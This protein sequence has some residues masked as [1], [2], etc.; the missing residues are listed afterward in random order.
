MLK[1][2]WKGLR[3]IEIAIMA[4][5]ITMLIAVVCSHYDHFACRSMQSEAKFSL[6]EI[7]NAQL[8]YHAEYDRFATVKK[9]ITE[10]LRVVVAQKYYDFSDAVAPNQDS[11]TIL[12]TGKAQTLVAG[13]IWSIDEKKR[14]INL[15]P[16]CAQP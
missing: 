2:F 16:I 13:E 5:L 15:N 1:R 11:F 6:Q 14:L 3:A 12:A 10:D 9:L 7:L 8:L 4:M